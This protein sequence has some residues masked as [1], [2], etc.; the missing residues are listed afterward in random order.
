MTNSFATKV[1][2]AVV[3]TVITTTSFAEVTRAE[4]VQFAYS[5][6]ELQSAQGV[7]AVESRISKLARSMCR[8]TSPIGAQTL[9][10]KCRENVVAQLEGKIWPAGK[11]EPIR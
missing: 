6:A 5:P 10:K 8:D 11:R 1:A 9:R 3:A 7:A 4:T 2:S